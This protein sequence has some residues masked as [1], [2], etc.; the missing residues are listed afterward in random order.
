MADHTAI[1]AVSRT[2]RTLL[3]DRMVTAD[4]AVTIAPPDVTVT[5]IGGA[6]VN[7]YLFQVLENAEL[8][9]QEIPGH[10]HPAAYGR[11]PLSLNLRYL[12]TTHSATETQPDS[13][14]NAQTSLGD[15]MRVLYHFGN[16]IDALTITNPAAGP[17]GDRILDAALRNEFERVKIV[18]HP[19]NLDD[20]TKVWSALSEENFRRSVVYEATVVQLEMAE[21]RPAP[22]PVETRRI[23]ASVRRRPVIRQVYV[24]PGAGEP[25]GELRVRVGEEVTIVAEHTLADRL[26]VRFGGLDLIRVSPP[27]DGRIRIAVPDDIYPVDLDN[28][29]VRP[30]P[31]ADRLQPGPIEVQVIAEHPAEGVEGGLGAGVNINPSRRYTSNTALLQLVPQVTGVAPANGAAATILQVTGTRLWHDRAEIAEVIIGDAAVRIRPPE[32]GD[33][34]TAPTPTAVEIPVAEAASLLPAPLPG[35]DP[36]PV[37]VQ[38]D[39]ARSRDDGF[40]FTLLP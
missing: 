9:N 33:P 18:L 40:D 8:K 19:A 25:L 36:Y 20:F 38:V 2:L 10:G 30:V 22:R 14:L 15:A 31:A 11:P 5:G 16:R 1:A 28:P 32:P 34:W 39:G 12:L 7:L 24:T 23:L 37:A 13:D 6:R 35:D 21:P 3:I 29:M 27:G 17:V 4:T 26:Y